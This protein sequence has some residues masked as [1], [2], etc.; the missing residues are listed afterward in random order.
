MKRKLQLESKSLSDE[1]IQ[2]VS[3]ELNAI[4]RRDGLIIPKAVV[5]AAREGDSPLHSFF[6]WNN[7]KAAESYREWQ[8][9][10]LIAQVFV[11]DLNQG[12]DGPV[13]RAFVN[14]KAVSQGEDDEDTTVRGYCSMQTVL[15]NSSMQEQVVQYARSHLLIW[16]KK[17]G[18]LQQFMEVSHAITKVAKE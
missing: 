9:R 13:V 11:R 3:G 10:A 18:H 2:I 1:Q 4:E 7:G 16:K 15:K 14:I 12:E 5:D 8:A 17:F 6:E